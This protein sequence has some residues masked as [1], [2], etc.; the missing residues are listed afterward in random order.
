MCQQCSI[1]L[2]TVFLSLL[3]FKKNCSITILT[4]WIFFLLSTGQVRHY[5]IL[6]LW[7]INLFI[8]TFFILIAWRFHFISHWPH[9]LNYLGYSSAVFVYKKKF[10]HLRCGAISTKKLNLSLERNNSCEWFFFS[11]L[12][13]QHFDRNVIYVHF[14]SRKMFKNSF[15]EEKNCWFSMKIECEIDNCDNG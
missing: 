12:L 6:S 2:F 8:F 15:F 7:T 11:F 10:V 9:A 5:L 1:R 3:T 4:Q 14:F 13:Y